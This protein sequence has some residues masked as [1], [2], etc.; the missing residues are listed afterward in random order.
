MGPD[1][2]IVEGSVDQPYHVQ[3]HQVVGYAPDIPVP[4][5][6]WRSVGA[7]FN[8]FF[9]EC[10]L[11]EMAVANKIDPLQMRLDMSKDFRAANEVLKALREFSGWDKPMRK[12]KA[13]GLAMTFSFGSYTAQVIEVSESSNGIKIDKVYC[14]V[15][16]GIALDPG[17]IEAQ[18]QSGIIYGLSAAI[19]GEIT[20]DEGIV[21]QSNFHDYSAL[22]L[23]QTPTIEVKILENG[24]SIQGIGEPGTPPSKPALANAIFAL[25]GQR[26]REYP[27]NKHVKF[28]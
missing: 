11:D 7:S 19:M 25:T 15:D 23:A 21:Q 2:A 4:L 17:N 5:G 12:G 3:N 10:F 9:H 20:F 27:L 8:G 13:R 18:I 14:V 1:K 26:I 22:K 6:F 16:P 28:A 24:S